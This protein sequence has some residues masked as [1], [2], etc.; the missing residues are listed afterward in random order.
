M[1]WFPSKCHKFI[2][3]FTV[4]G[5]KQQSVVTAVHHC[6]T[7]TLLSSKLHMSFI[8]SKWQLR[9]GVLLP[10]QF[11]ITRWWFTMT[12]LSSE[13]NSFVDNFKVT[14][15]K[16]TSRK[17]IDEIVFVDDW[18]S[19]KT[20]SA[21]WKFP[22]TR[23]KATDE[24]VNSV[25]LRSHVVQGTSS[26]DWALAGGIYG[27]AKICQLDTLVCHQQNILRLDIPMDD[28][29]QIESYIEINAVE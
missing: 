2:H 21:D 4:A 6:L 20:A 23:Q 15:Q 5:Q 11:M 27:Q 19:L 16:V 10:Q 9:N 17:A 3:D 7:M 24:W 12:Y 14:S 8:I 26:C 18:P 25:Y 29:L 13:G 28:A 1:T 22:E